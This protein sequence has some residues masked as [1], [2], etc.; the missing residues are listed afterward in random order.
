MRVNDVLKTKTSGVITARSDEIIWTVLVRYR[1]HQVGTLVVVDDDGG[2]VGLLSER[3]LVNGLL[4]WGKGLLDLPVGRVMSTR[5]ATC[6]PDDPVG[7]VMTL[8]TERRTRHLPVIE[9]GRVRD[10]ISIGDVVKA[11]LNDV[12]LEN[13]ILR[14]MTRSRH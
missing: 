7:R 3:D 2:L 14:D 8:M 5:V 13:R 1:R 11:R 12:E 10:I 6:G 4:N 9:N